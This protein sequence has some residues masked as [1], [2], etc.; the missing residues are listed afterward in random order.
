M[1]YSILLVD[2]EPLALDGYRRQLNNYF[3]IQTA[4]SGYEGLKMLKNYGPFAAVVVD[5][6]MPGMNGVDFTV[7][8]R[9][10]AP[11]TIRLMLT[12]KGDLQV[13]TEALN[14]GSIFMFLSKPYPADQFL[15]AIVS[16]VEKYRGVECNSEQMLSGQMQGLKLLYK[17]ILQWNKGKAHP[18]IKDLLG[19]RQ[20]FIDQSDASN[21]ARVN[22]LISGMVILAGLPETDSDLSY[23]LEDLA[24]EAITIFEAKG[25]PALLR[26]EHDLFAPAL[27]WAYKNNI[28]KAFLQPLLND[29]GSPENDSDLLK[30]RTLGSLQV[31]FDGQ[32]I[33]ETDW[34]NPKVKMLFLYLLT[35]RL[36]KVDR[37]IIYDLFWPEMKPQSAGNNFSSAL[38]TLR[39]IIGS[40]KVAYTKGLCWLAKDKYW[41]DADDFKEAIKTARKH[42]LSG[43][44]EKAIP[45]YEKAILL[46]HGDYLEEYTYEDWITEERERL[47]A[48]YTKA[49]I[50]LADLLADRGKYIE[51]AETLEKTPRSEVCDDHFLYKLVN[52]YIL[53]GSRSKAIRRFQ[54]YRAIMVSELGIEPGPSIEWLFNQTATRA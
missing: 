15:G 7:D 3:D 32:G 25:F 4:T 23:S 41:C 13:A 37:E 5:Y 38:Y 28:N 30:F 26:N 9:Q 20:I 6:M 44:E 31:T 46:Y 53:A 12:G 54:H 21:L 22:L 17:G 1:N 52:Y 40:D 49:L 43:N 36:K 48:L 51:A 34:R 35:N 16:A 18:A 10:V 27:N 47:R 11:E 8:A 29:L 50:E 39:Q 2:D 24:R 42:L 14:R 19:A 45:C 33:E